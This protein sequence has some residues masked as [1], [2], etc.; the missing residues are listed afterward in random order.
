MPVKNP[1]EEEI[2]LSSD[3]TKGFVGETINTAILDSG[4][5]K[6]VCG[7]VWLDCYLNSLSTEDKKL[8]KTEDSSTKFRF[9]SGDP[10]P[11]I[12]RVIMPAEISGKKIFIRTE[13]VECDLPLLLSK[14]AMKRTNTVLTSLLIQSPFLDLHKDFYLHL[15]VTTVFR[16]AAIYL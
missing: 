15:L 7:A 11:S 2:Y 8:V 3:N 5:T 13:V 1:L 14:E 6:T 9:G 12:K 10:V 4:C 16:L